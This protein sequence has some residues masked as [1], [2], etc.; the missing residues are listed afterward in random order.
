[1]TQ[2]LPV[3][4]SAEGLAKMNTVIVVVFEAAGLTVSETKAE[5]VLL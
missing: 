1:M 2:D 5:A 3:S 4:R